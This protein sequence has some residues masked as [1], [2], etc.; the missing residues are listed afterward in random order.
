[1]K[2]NINWTSNEKEIANF[3][4]MVGKNDNNEFII[5][6]MKSDKQYLLKIIGVNNRFYFDTIKLAQAW[7]ENYTNKIN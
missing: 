6:K 1:M 3:F 5:S 2:N 7:C 4:Q